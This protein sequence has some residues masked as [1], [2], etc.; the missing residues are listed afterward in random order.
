MK[1]IICI[2]IM[3]LMLLTGST[4]GEIGSY[5]QTV[6]KS[7]NR[8]WK[9]QAYVNLEYMKYRI[10]KITNDTINVKNK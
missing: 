1:V 4:V 7:S 6:V 5:K 9:E 3:M 8:Y 2:L 10:Y